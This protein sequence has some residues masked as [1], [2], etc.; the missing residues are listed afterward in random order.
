MAM[1]LTYSVTQAGT[2]TC[3]VQVP[4]GFGAGMVIFAVIVDHSTTNANSTPVTGWTARG[5]A[6][7]SGYRFQLFSAAYGRNS[8]AA[9]PWTFT[10]LTTRSQGCSVSCTEADTVTENDCTPTFRHNASGTY[11]TT[12][13]TPVTNGA[14]V[15]AAFCSY[16]NGTAWGSESVATGPTLTEHFDA[17]NST[18]CSIAIADGVL[19]TAAATGASNATPV[20]AAIN[21]GMLFAIRPAPPVTLHGLSLCGVGT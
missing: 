3:A 12:S 19:A 1:T 8:L 4:A 11:G 10:G 15:L 13:I 14:V 17:P 7:S 20:T 5:Y 16:A 9:G 2:T 21:G 6:Y 18:Y